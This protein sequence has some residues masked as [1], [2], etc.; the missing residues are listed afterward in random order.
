MKK[1]LLCLLTAMA[2]LACCVFTVSAS[3]SVDFDD[4]IGSMKPEAPVLSLAGD[5]NTVEVS[6]TAAK[7][8]VTYSVVLEK[9]TIDADG[10]RWVATTVA[11]NISALSYTMEVQ[12]GNYRVKV[13]AYN[14]LKE[15]S[16]E[17]ES[18]QFYSV[19]Y[20]FN[21]DGALSDADA[22]Y[23]LRHVT[24]GYPANETQADVNGDG[25]VTDADALQLLRITLFPDRF[26]N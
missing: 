10:A 14:G 26:A 15:A 2:V 17:Y 8:A 9:F 12:S 23:L 24:L 3:G 20:D 7:N 25:N 6:W 21:C 11:D 19:Q 5:E 18:F 13:V 16:S 22:I 4:L 1:R